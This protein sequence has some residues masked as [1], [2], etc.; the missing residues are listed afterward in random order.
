MC[1]FLIRHP[2]GKMAGQTSDYHASTH[3]VAPTILGFLGIVPPEQ[4]EG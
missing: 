1:P 2:G 4:M 3:D